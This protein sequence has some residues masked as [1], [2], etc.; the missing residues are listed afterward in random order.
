MA[1]QVDFRQAFANCLPRL[2]RFWP[3]LVFVLIP[4]TFLLGSIAVKASEQ[5]VKESSVFT[6]GIVLGFISGLAATGE[7]F[8]AIPA[9]GPFAV[10]GM[11]SGAISSLVGFSPTWVGHTALVIIAATIGMIVGLGIQQDANDGGNPKA[12]AEHNRDT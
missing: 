11:F 9:G 1:D 6:G 8:Y 4:V 3:H 12:D 7:K 2:K 5:Q 10:V